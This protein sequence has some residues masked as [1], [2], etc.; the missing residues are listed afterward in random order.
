[1][2]S[3][4]AIIAPQPGQAERGAHRL[5]RSGNRAMTTFKKLPSTKPKTNTNARAI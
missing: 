1:M 3:N 5:R 4:Q 2:L